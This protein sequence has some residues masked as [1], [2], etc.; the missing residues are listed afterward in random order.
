MGAA[1][2][3]LLTASIGF[4]YALLT[5]IN[6][7]VSATSGD[8]ASRA[9]AT[10]CT[11][12]PTEFVTDPNL[13]AVIAGTNFTRQILVRFGFR[14]HTFHFGQF[15]SGSG[16]LTTSAE[17]KLVGKIPDAG[18][19]QFQVNVT[20]ASVGIPRPPI[21][22]LFSVVGVAQQFNEAPLHFET[23]GLVAF[24]TTTQS[25]ALPTAVA[26]D[27]YFYSIAANGGVPPYTFTVLSQGSQRFMPQGVAFD[28]AHALLYGKPLTPT[29]VGSPALIHILLS[30]HS[31]SQ[32]T[33]TFSLNVL[34]GT[35]SSQAV[36]TSGSMQL[37]YGNDNLFDSLSLTLILDKSD[38]GAQNIRTAA[39]LNGLPI[40]I[41]FGGFQLPPAAQ[42]KSKTKIINTFNA[43]GKI[44]VP[45]TQLVQGDVV[46]SGVKDVHYQ[47]KLD[48][49][50]GILSARFTNINMLKTIGANFNSFEGQDDP[51]NRGPVI[52]I[53]IKIGLTAKTDLVNGAND[54]IEKT[55][56]IKFV[57]KR[58][59][60]IG[61]G[62]ARFNDNLAP[63]GIFLIN[64]VS[65]SE[66][67][68]VV[69][70]A[71]NVK[72]DRLFLQMKGLMRQ[73][74]AKPVIPAT[75]DMVSVFI[76]RL[77]L[78]MFP[79][80][81]FAVN[82]SQLVFANDDPTKGLK[83]LVIDNQK[84]TVLITTHGLAASQ[85]L[86]GVDI[87]VAGDPET[88]PITLTIGGPDLHNPTF[89]GQSTV[90]I[91]RKGKNIV[92]K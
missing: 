23:G 73:P 42:P 46:G 8:V 27:S 26:G 1:K 16:Q 79:A 89:D 74:G 30:D 3:A 53:N 7:S 39:D 2:W 38:L 11:R 62:T 52:P 76:N 18:V 44:S 33:G 84:G 63:A 80:S 47:I 31:G 69:D 49:K 81:S 41:N 64:K 83:D 68:V 77:C 19:S 13:G 45:P 6:P 12:L 48:P 59:G 21:S 15:S 71:T 92:N 67:Q 85:N 5:S 91:F 88:V 34:P 36:A 54:I 66:A 29:P 20:D 24:G 51:F 55:D 32:V 57:Y 61:K 60:S 43:A 10:N 4:T 40:S 25:L 28:S 50:T 56:V 17:G 35:I 65:G 82:G 70:A 75:G 37:N 58:N 72:E 78:G 14:P 86:F 9:L 87:L 90:S 22:R